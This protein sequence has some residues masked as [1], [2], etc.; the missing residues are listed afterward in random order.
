MAKVGCKGK[1]EY[2]RTNDGLMLIKAWARDGLTHEQIAHNIGINVATLYDWK[3]R[4]DD[5]GEALKRG[6]EVVD[7]EVENALLKRAL[8]YTVIENDRERYIPPDVGAMCFWLKNR[9]GDTWRDRKDVAVDASV[10]TNPYHGL[11]E[12]ELKKLAGGG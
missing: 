2:W 10:R 3:S 9:K 1:Y 5:I 4:F 6:R 12:D 11:T 7:F 8:G